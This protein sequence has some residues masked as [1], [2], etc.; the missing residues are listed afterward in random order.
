MDKRVV[1]IVWL[2]GVWPARAPAQEPVAPLQSLQSL[3]SPDGRLSVE[4]TLPAAGTTD[5]PRWSA[6]FAGTALLEDC[7][8]GLI[9]QGPQD[10]LAGARALGAERGA[11]D[12]RIAVWFG[13]ADHALDRCEELRLSLQRD[14][15]PP[16]RIV[17]RCYDDAIAWRYEV[18]A[19][20]GH[21]PLQLVGESTSFSFA[22]SPT[23][24]T[25][26]LANFRTS[27][28]HPVVAVPFAELPNGQ[29]LDLPL[30]AAFAGGPFVSIT[31]AALRHYAGMSLRRAA[32]TRELVAVLTPRDDGI[33]VVRPLPM[34]TPWRVVLVGATPGALL[35][36]NTLYCLNDPPAFDPGWIRPGKITWPWWNGGLFG[37]ARDA[38]E[39]SVAQNTKYVDWCA[40]NGIAF[41]AVVAAEDDT[42]WYRQSQRGFFPGPDTDATRPR[43]D[44][45]LAAIRAHADER[46]VRLWTWVHH[47]AVRGRTEAVFAAFERLGFAGTMVDFLD[48]DDQDTVEFAE[49]VLTAAARHHVL[50][51]FHGMYKPS[52]TQRTFPNLMN[53]EGSL[54]LEYLKWGAMCTPE[55]TL[56]VA[57]TRL[58]AGPMDYHL[59]GF[60]AVP[61]ARFQPKNVAPNVLGTRGHQLAMYVCFDNPTPMVADYPEAYHDQPGFDFVR[62]VPTWWDETRVLDAEIGRLLVTARRR[63]RVWWLGAL[64]AGEAREIAVP[65]AFL[66]KGPHA[67]QLWRDGDEAARDP[68]QLALDAA[69]RSATDVLRVRLGP[70]GGFVA[71]LTPR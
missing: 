37:P 39:L 41:H 13:K 8:L 35:A 61:R 51:H 30:T 32:G 18:A 47:G 15:S 42:P 5:L 17:L 58:V 14:G 44:L 40:T 70:D 55:H 62:E 65:L 34:V 67:L 49:E 52:G 23:V 53:H 26:Y 48:H 24:Y 45:D 71:R 1:A 64:A 69:E 22:G 19:A 54:N 56:K 59:G 33:A 36:S 9:V 7:R 46:G 27:H 3:H 21:G 12:E 63:G 57:F 66:G 6:T 43:D 60:R 20:A 31:E 28:E 25:S 16:V 50:V 38:G 29:L 11:R 2:F 68:N 10:L 4:L